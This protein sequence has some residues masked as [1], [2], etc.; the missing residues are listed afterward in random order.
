MAK[1]IIEGDKK[2][3]L[4]LVRENRSRKNRWGLGITLT[5]EV[6]TPKG[7]KPSALDLIEAISKV[8]SLEDLKEFESDKRVTVI[9]AVE[10]KKKE[11]DLA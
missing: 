2:Y 10:S 5:E 1:L 8:E 7:S 3:L 11:L 9:A 4:K 6:E